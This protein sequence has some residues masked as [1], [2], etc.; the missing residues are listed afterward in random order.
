MPH[1]G[2]SDL[3]LH[4]L[5]VSLIKGARLRWIKIYWMYMFMVNG[6]SNEEMV[7]FIE[8]QKNYSFCW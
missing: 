6:A 7:F 3:V 2:A 4:C 5:P 1:S 8:K